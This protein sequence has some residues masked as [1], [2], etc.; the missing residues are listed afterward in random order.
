MDWAL[1]SKVR[2]VSRYC[3]PR[4]E[5]CIVMI[6][7][8]GSL[9]CS[10][11]GMSGALSN[12]CR[13]GRSGSLTQSSLGR[14]R[15]SRGIRGT[16]QRMVSPGDGRAAARVACISQKRARRRAQLRSRG[17]DRLHDIRGGVRVVPDV[18]EPVIGR[19]F[20]RPV[21]SS[22]LLAGLVRRR[23]RIRLSARTRLAVVAPVSLGR[24]I[25]G[26]ELG[27]EHDQGSLARLVG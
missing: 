1:R 2:A 26:A 15:S 10:R 7:S 16:Y 27:A 20:A 11:N 5:I 4:R 23:A 18:A 12:A 6:P 22:G 8:R 13:L 17:A 21:G 24:R 14:V 25:V 19:A 9:A 3:L